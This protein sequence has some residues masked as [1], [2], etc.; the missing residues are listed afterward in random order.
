MQHINLHKVTLRCYLRN[1]LL[2]LCYYVDCSTLERGKFSF[3]SFAP[4]FLHRC[5]R[6]KSSKIRGRR[7]KREKAS[8]E[9]AQKKER[10]SA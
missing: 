5:E 4:F 9:A 7:Q 8:K 1:T 6:K 2:E 3:V 10:E